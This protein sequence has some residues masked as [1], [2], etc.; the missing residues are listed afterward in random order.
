MKLSSVSMR[1]VRFPP[2]PMTSSPSI[3]GS[4]GAAGAAVHVP[5]ADVLARLGRAEGVQGDRVADADPPASS[6]VDV[7]GPGAWCAGMSDERGRPAVNSIV[8]NS[9]HP[10]W[11]T[12][13][14][15][16]NSTPSIRP[17]YMSAD[18]PTTSGWAR[19]TAT[20]RACSPGRWRR[21]RDARRSPGPAPSR[22]G[23]ADRG[24]EHDTRPETGEESEEQRATPPLAEVRSG[25]QNGAAVHH[26]SLR[27]TS[28]GLTP[29]CF[30]GRAR[31]RA[32]S[33]AS[34]AT[35]TTT[36]WIG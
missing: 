29:R 18:A 34:S 12:M 5:R 11:G 30:D 36:R 19:T 21:P 8:L 1:L 10:P 13:A 27:R 2:I 31:A 22:C 32:R 25:P 7:G 9:A 28:A 4:Q 23:G 6:A 35:G 26:H 20:L 3:T 16:S 15:A 14:K 24:G 17:R 33:I